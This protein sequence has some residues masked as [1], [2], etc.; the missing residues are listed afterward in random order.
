M[1]SIAKYDIKREEIKAKKQNAKLFPFYKM[2]SWDLLFFYSTQYL[3]FTVV[4]GLTAGEI[5]KVN[6]F[7]PL[8]III[9]QLPAA[10]C[11]DFLGRKRS[12]VLGN[13]V[14]MVYIFLLICLPGM[15]GIFIANIVYA[16]GYSLKAIQETNIL[17]DSTSTKGGEGLYPKINAK[18]ASGY[19]LLDGIASLISGY[20]FVINGYLPMIICLVFTLISTIISTKFKDIYVNQ[21][22]QNYLS[23]K[24]KEYKNDF[25]VS[26]KNIITSQRL[27]A[28]LLFMG[29]FNALLSI[30]S[31]YS[32]NILTE[33]S[34]KPES[35]S[36]INA[37]L[38][39]IAGIAT[40]FQDK[41]H[42]KFKNRTFTFLSLTFSISIILIGGILYSRANNILPIIL[43]LFAIRNITMSNYYVLSERYSKNFST[44][45]TRTRISFAV[46]FSTNM[47]EAILLFLAGVLLDGTNIT[48]ATL[49]IGLL[50]FIL[51]IFILN[52]MKTR[53]GLKP[54]EYKKTDIQL[55]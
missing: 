9:M 20:L 29:L 25:K 21:L 11:A 35:F 5:L 27:R 55:E 7:Y 33:L 47:I 3:F 23:H 1:K 6:A 28:L 43:V 18:G 19:Y 53:V 40:A 41:I 37:V 36:I 54:G 49:F 16:F 39:L 50:S 30:M 22:E 44:P 17:Y 52:Y 4:K 24:I 48:F 51:F 13:I 45:K 10:I 2:F 15:I 31:T 8:F 14:L 12:I 46:E 42:Q 26:I 34:V 38:T 32:G